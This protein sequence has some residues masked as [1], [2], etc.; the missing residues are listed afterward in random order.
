[1]LLRRA[2]IAK[3]DRCI[4]YVQIIA[5]RA[6]KPMVALA[7]VHNENGVKDIPETVRI[8]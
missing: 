8:A 1:M 6:S 5:R 2:G 3:T 4:G 7:L